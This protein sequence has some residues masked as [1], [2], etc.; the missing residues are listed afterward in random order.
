MSSRQSDSDA[1]GRLTDRRV[2]RVDFSC[3]AWAWQAPLRRDREAIGTAARSRVSS[4]AKRSWPGAKRW[5]M[6]C[7]NGKRQCVDNHRACGA[8][9]ALRVARSTPTLDGTR[10]G[11]EKCSAVV[12]CVVASDSKLSARSGL[13]SYVI[14][15][16]AEK[17]ADPPTSPGLACVVKISACFKARI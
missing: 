4:P 10:R 1:P 11:G 15:L 13:L 3:G 14:A 12:A 5:R 2:Q 16:V 6:G 7:G 17:S 9:A 8:P